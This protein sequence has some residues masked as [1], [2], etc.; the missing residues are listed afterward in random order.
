[1]RKLISKIKK[2]KT[3]LIS[4]VISIL[5]AAI[6]G[7]I[8]MAITG[9]NP[10]DG[11]VAMVKGAFGNMRVLGN[12]LAKTLTLCL[13]ALAT[14]LGA[15]AG[16]FNV[17][18]EGQLFL[19]GLAATVVGVGLHG[20]SPWIVVP[21]AFISAAV[22]GGFYAFI[23]GIM[24]VKL[25]ISEVITTI[26]LNSCA[27]FFCS[28]LISSNGPFRTLDRGNMAASDMID[29]A[30][31]FTKLIPKS[32]LSTALIYSAIIAFIC[33]YIMQKSTMGLEMKATGENVRFGFF[34]GL[35]TDKIMV[36]A[37]VGSG[38]ICGLVGMFQIYGY[39]NRFTS[40]IS[41]EYFY[42]GMLVAMIMNYNPL[43][44]IIMSLFFAM[45]DIGSTAMEF[46]VGVSGELSDVIFAIIVF[47][48]A[49]QKSI[50]GLVDKISRKRS[51]RRQ[52]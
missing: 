26:M 22:V 50:G 24:R 13:T 15:K 44:I 48:M 46:S 42:D 51:E 27:I 3:Y 21:L 40:S 32:N 28:Y 20:M 30:F 39:Q 35:D 1:M 9:C 18:G 17:G 29:P 52:A 23:P 16:M 36:L 37:M 33:W 49:A 11:Y 41:N 43:G 31:A 38:I 34:S 2:N 12:T 19:G 25:G 14:A 8:L 4:L 7:A 45:I 47:Q 10:I 5:T 6:I